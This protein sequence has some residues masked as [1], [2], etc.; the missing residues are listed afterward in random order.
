MAA[1]QAFVEALAWAAS[2]TLHSLP[3]VVVVTRGVHACVEGDTVRGIAI[4]CALFFFKSLLV[5][6][7]DKVTSVFIFRSVFGGGRGGI[8]LMIVTK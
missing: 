1:F 7:R 5:R 8:F 3:D 6:S 4:D 2:V